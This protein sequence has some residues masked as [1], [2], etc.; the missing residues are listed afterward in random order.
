MNTNSSST[1][2]NVALPQ[3]LPAGRQDPRLS[4]F[5]WDGALAGHQHVTLPGHWVS[6][7]MELTKKL[8]QIGQYQLFSPFGSQAAD[9]FKGLEEG[10]VA[11]DLIINFVTS[12]LNLHKA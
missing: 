8:S 6:E 4:R 1:V 10:G 3:C 2:L 9:V 5:G 7:F 11:V 12:L